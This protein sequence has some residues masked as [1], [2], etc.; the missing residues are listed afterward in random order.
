[1]GTEGGKGEGWAAPRG[2]WRFQG[3]N[4]RM[5]TVARTPGEALR[6][7]TNN[8]FRRPAKAAAHASGGQDAVLRRSPLPFQ[9]S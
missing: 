6:S 9:P 3:K 4:V 8:A 7:P 2:G 1:M 5:L